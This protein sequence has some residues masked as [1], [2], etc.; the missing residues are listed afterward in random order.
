MQLCPRVCGGRERSGADGEGVRR[1]EA[2]ARHGP[3]T[4]PQEMSR[5]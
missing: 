1:H 4:G 5:D 3:G 2:G